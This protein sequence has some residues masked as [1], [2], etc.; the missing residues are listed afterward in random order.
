VRDLAGGPPNRNLG[1]VAER[2]ARR[3]AAL[4]GRLPAPGSASLPT[5]L[6]RPDRRAARD[7][8]RRALQEQL[9]AIQQFRAQGA[10]VAA[11]ARALQLNWKTVHKYWTVTEAPE[12][13]YT[14]RRGSALAPHASYLEARWRQ[15]ERNAR[16]LWRELRRRGYPGAYQNVARYVAALRRLAGTGQAGAA[17]RPGLTV[18]HAVALAL[19]RP[20]RRT[21]AEQETLARVKAL[22]PDVARVLTLLEAF[23]ALLRQRPVPD[24]APR[25]DAWEAAAQ[26]T[27]APEVTAFIAKLEHDRAAVEAALAL[28]YSQGQTEGQI[29]RLKALKRAMFGRANF[30]LLR[31]RFLAASR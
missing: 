13:R 16:G 26:A 4:I 22:H 24:A 30:D 31:K 8:T 7:R 15:G 27:G 6:L 17:P 5:T 21:A 28:P 29:T 3:H 19:R 25:L 23:A 18:R 11:T 2:V 14:G 10:S 20:E 12:R 1:R 9:T